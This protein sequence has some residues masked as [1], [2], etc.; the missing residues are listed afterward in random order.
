MGDYHRAAGL[1]PAVK[2]LEAAA[3]VVPLPQAPQPIAI[4][5]YGAASGHDSL[6]PISAAIRALRRRTRPDH[7]ILVAHTDRP[8]N[9][10]TALFETLTKDPESYLNMDGA[11]FSSAVGRAFYSQIL[12]SNTIALGWSSFAIH[13]LSRIPRAIPDHVQISYSAD[14]DARRAFARQ[15]AWDWHE[16]V[17]FRGRE[18]AP[19]GRL[20][21]A[22]LGLDR[23][24]KP[25][26]ASA[27]NAIIGTLRELVGDG[28]LSAD[29]AQ[30][31]CIPI[32]G[33]S[34]EDFLAPFAPSGRFE[35]LSITH[36][37]LV[38]AEDRFW[39]R[40]QTDRDANGFGANWAATLRDLAFPALLSAL[41]PARDDPRATPLLDRLETGLARRLADAP[42][43]MTIP[44]AMLVL[45]KRL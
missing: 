13:R 7:A 20:V 32:T 10:F 27:L 5:D 44:L 43:P 1:G 2:L 17:A 26:F 18:L 6:L 12:P 40:F 24:E 30:R 4:A 28:L 11:A 31:M 37:E 39:T 35:G 38:A 22:T 3:E 16:F 45:E 14:P 8:D 41:D 21:V 29:E 34:E 9:N 23:D 42:T 36:L 19:G 25:G 15:A 33:R